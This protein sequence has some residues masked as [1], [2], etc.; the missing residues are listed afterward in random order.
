VTSPASIIEAT[1]L[2]FSAGAFSILKGLNFAV[3]RGSFCAVLGPNGGGKSTLLRLILGLLKP[4]TGRIAVTVGESHRPAPSAVGYV[5]QVKTLD[6]SFPALAIDLVASGI[7]AAWPWQLDAAQR[8]RAEHALEQA[9][10]LPLAG[11]QLSVLS[12][13]ELQRAYLAR[14]LVREPQLILL[15]EPAAGIDL[16]G[17]HDM[18]L[19][20]EA[21]QRRTGATVVMVTHDWGA[22]YH[23]ATQALVLSR[24]LLAA[25][26]PAAVLSDETMRLAFGHA[27][28]H[29][30]M[31][32]A[33][34]HRHA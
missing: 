22:A 7:H 12:G 5:P 19:V 26:A 1:E 24:E 9:G 32:L 8:E 6:R 21:Y 2:G 16:A 28:H 11:R 31:G 14:A 3:P 29:H 15:D 17:E 25:G 18:Y 33:E 20:L 30:G 4:T 13:G 23:H 27:G 10:A 34:E